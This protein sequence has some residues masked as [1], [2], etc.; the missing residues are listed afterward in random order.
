MQFPVFITA[1]QHSSSSI[2]CASFGYLWLKIL[3]MFMSIISD[4]LRDPEKWSRRERVCPKIGF[5]DAGVHLTNYRHQTEKKRDTVARFLQKCTRGVHKGCFMRSI[6]PATRKGGTWII[7]C[8][9]GS[10]LARIRRK[11]TDIPSD[12]E[13]VKIL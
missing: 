6:G 3:E 5:I 2:D 8:C 11:S 7:N 12:N 4:S 10:R 9:T 13:T 1:F